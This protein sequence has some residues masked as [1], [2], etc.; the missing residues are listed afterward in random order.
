MPRQTFRHA[1]GGG[2]G[3]HVRVPVVFTGKRYEFSIR[4]EQGIAFRARARR[5][6]LRLAAAAV[7]SP[8]VPGIRKN[9][10][11]LI[12][13]WGPEQ[14]RVRRKEG[15]GKEQESRST[16]HEGEYS[17]GREDRIAYRTPG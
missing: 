10:I 12:D 6:A 1:T 8:K 5:Q 14:S 4:R 16:Q 2:N 9:Y 3:E 11:R 7:D 17:A 13:G 15:D